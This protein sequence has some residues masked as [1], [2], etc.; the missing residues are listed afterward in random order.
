MVEVHLKILSIDH[1]SRSPGD[2]NSRADRGH[3]DDVAIVS[4]FQITDV[5]VVGQDF[6]PQLEIGRGFEY[7]HL[8]RV[9]D[10][11]I[12]GM[13]RSGDACA[14]PP[15]EDRPERN[16]GNGFADVYMV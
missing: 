16:L 12:P 10:D 4:S 14:T 1:L 11:G 7:H 15:L 5:A 9:Y 3:Q 6:R 8:R 13:H 2:G